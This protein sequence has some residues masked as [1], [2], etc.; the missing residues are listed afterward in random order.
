MII[1]FIIVA[2]AIILGVMWWYVKGLP[3]DETEK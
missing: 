2:G 1:D 3:E